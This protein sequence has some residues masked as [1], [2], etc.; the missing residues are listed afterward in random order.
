MPPEPLP[1]QLTNVDST[2]TTCCNAVQIMFH[3]KATFS[4]FMAKSMQPFLPVHLKHLLDENKTKKDGLTRHSSRFIWPCLGRPNHPLPR[5]TYKQQLVFTATFPISA[6]GRSCNSHFITPRGH[7]KDKASSPINKTN[8]LIQVSHEVDERLPAS[9]KVPCRT[10]FQ[11]FI[12]HAGLGWSSP[13]RLI[14]PQIS[15]KRHI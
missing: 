4:H 5:S 8:V 3:Q 15:R 9:L 11:I 14:I 13:A 7:V 2:L 1:R 6:Q 10:H 12:F